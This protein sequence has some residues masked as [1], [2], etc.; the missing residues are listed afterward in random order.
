GS[1]RGEFVSSYVLCGLGRPEEFPNSVRGRIALIKRG[2]LTFNQKVRNAQAAGAL[3]VVIYNKDTYDFKNW[4][5]LR[6]DCE[7]IEGCDDY[8]RAWPVVLG[9]SNTD[10]QRLADDSTRTMDMGSWLDDY[11]FMN[12][13]SMA[14]PHVSG[15]LALIW[16]LA[17]DAS[18][19]RV[20]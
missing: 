10:G 5:L 3:S 17:P 16:S 9:I 19:G 14:C 4:T 11:T 6:P 8:D 12:G 2:D 20:R 18:P 1:M 7:A 13:T 15:A